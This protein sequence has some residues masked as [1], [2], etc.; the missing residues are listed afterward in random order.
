MPALFDGTSFLIIESPCNQ[1]S[2]IDWQKELIEKNLGT[3]CVLAVESSFPDN[4]KI[5]HVIMTTKEVACIRMV[6]ELMLPM[7]TPQWLLD[8]DLALQKKNY[9]LYSPGPPALFDRVVICVADNVPESH[10]ALIYA[11]TREF[12]GQYLDVLSRYTTH[13]ISTDLSNSKAIL[14]SS[15]K[16]EN[17]QI[18]IVLPHWFYD[19]IRQ[20]A[21]LDASPYSLKDKIVLQTGEPFFEGSLQLQSKLPVIQKIE[22]LVNRTV[23]LEKDYD[24]D[25]TFRGAIGAMVESC[26]GT[27]TEIFDDKVNTYVCKKR[28]GPNFD[29][30]LENPLM[31]VATM[32]WLYAVIQSSKFFKPTN[33]LHLPVFEWPVAELKGRR[34]SISG[35]SGDRRHYLQM[36]FTSM[37]AD[38]TK[39]LD[40][41]NDYLICSKPLGEKFAAAKNRWNHI[42]IVNHLWVEESYAKW[43]AL[44]PNIPRFKDLSPNIA[45]LGKLIAESPSDENLGEVKATN[46]ALQKLLMPN[47]SEA[48]RESSNPLEIPNDSLQ[49]D[50]MNVIE[51]FEIPTEEPP[52]NDSSRPRLSRLAKKVASLKLHSDMEDL[53]NY[54]SISK[55][56]RKM[57][58]FM[59][60]LERDYDTG[61]HQKGGTTSLATPSTP[62]TKRKKIGEIQLI[63]ITTG[64]EKDIVLHRADLIK[65][66]SVG[67]RII[68]D[69]DPKCK[70]LTIIAPKILRTE[71]FLKSLSLANRIIHPKYLT[72]V[73]QK[74]RKESLTWEGLSKEFNVDDY[75]LDKFL[76]VKQI[77]EELGVTKFLLNPFEALL[78]RS[79]QPVFF[80]MKINVSTNVNG[81]AELISS[82]LRQHGSSEVKIVKLASAT[83]YSELL[84]GETGVALVVVNKNKDAKAAADL[85]SATAV[86]WDWCVKSIFHRECQDFGP[87]IIRN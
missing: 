1:P 34:I 87:Y 76:P 57:K 81:G 79:A 56:A 37:G 55:S 9:R 20:Q 72:D 80:G 40:A 15:I 12:G 73:L 24:I 7:T 30:A 4:I 85:K 66:S 51:V 27:F 53:N 33:L 21:R 69:F 68:N 62:S 75:S 78:S 29:C 23:Y 67:I 38:F 25:Q 2:D 18:E 49:R 44:D 59:E 6:E 42:H 84:R 86:E 31:I 63:A 35:Y 64:C 17:L 47:H 36:L 14:A 32:T 45:P 46:P 28:G 3:V 50:D 8:S 16:Q 61:D 26:G 22:T 82:I 41:Q 71:K 10:K 70:E 48:L 60:E 39:T 11:A 19:C 65:L 52:H 77:K 13:L 58:H 54:T 83:I 74:L 5:D 43:E